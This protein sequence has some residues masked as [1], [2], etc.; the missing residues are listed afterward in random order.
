M[1]RKLR[2]KLKELD[3]DQKYL[4]K[5]FGLSQASISHR[6]T[7]QCSW[8]LDEMYVVMDLIQEPHEKLHEYFPKD[9]GVTAGRRA[10]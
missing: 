2:G 10:S 7:N 3:I 8:T 5:F 9:G 6:L 1:F 4:A